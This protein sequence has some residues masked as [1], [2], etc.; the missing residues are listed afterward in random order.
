MSFC[1]AYIPVGD[2]RN[3]PSPDTKP[4]LLR[5][6]RLYQADWLLRFY[7]FSAGEIL[8]E[9][10]PNFNPVLDPKCNWAV[11]HMERFPVE[12]MRAREEELLRV[13]GI[14]PKSARRILAARRAGKLDFKAVARLGVVMKRAQYFIT[15]AGKL[16]DGLRV[17]DEAILRALTSRDAAAI[18]SPPAEQLTLIPE[19][20]SMEDVRLCLKA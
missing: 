20:L 7:H 13:P 18:L 19:E 1:S 6:H 14:G 15:C 2:D 11:H 12:I 10:H 17:T 4:P 3:L 16:A 9:A 8:D 5:E